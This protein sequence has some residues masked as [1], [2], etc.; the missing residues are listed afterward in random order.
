MDASAA[1]SPF[2]SLLPSDTPTS[3]VDS[4]AP[5]REKILRAASRIPSPSPI[6]SI[7]PSRSLSSLSLGAPVDNASPASSEVPSISS[8]TYQSLLP[9]QVPAVIPSEIP[10]LALSEQPSTL[11]S[12]AP[13]DI[14]S[15][16][17]STSTL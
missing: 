13:G 12:V 8:S 2:E 3:R 7:Q 10:S 15:Q 6:D 4:E 5:S 16:V 9:S 14:P 17:P 1:L 11:P